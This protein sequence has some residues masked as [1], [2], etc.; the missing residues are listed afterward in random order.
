MPVKKRFIVL[1]AATV[2]CLA[3]AGVLAVGIGFFAL[4]EPDADAGLRVYQIDQVDSKH[5]GYRRSTMTDGGDVYVNDYEESA[6]QLAN[7]EPTKVIA[8]KGNFG[9]TKV[10][11][12]PG[13]PITAYVAADDGSEMPAYVVY[14]HDGQ[15]PFDWR[16]AQFREMAFISPSATNSGLTST[17]PAL[18]AEVVALLRGGTPVSLP[19]YF[20][21]G[22][23]QHGD[24]PHGQRSIARPAFLPGPAHRP[25][26][27]ALRG[28]KPEVRPHLHPA[29]LPSQ[30]DSR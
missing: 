15:P 1:I 25:R 24:P 3:A 26:W 13:Q 11:A 9:S 7:P 29:T 18:L 20:H 22:R 28:R 17:H 16:A 14:R 27:H 19:R 12:V 2:L 5:A 30:L 8:R 21:G 4:H 23:R 6:L 10:C